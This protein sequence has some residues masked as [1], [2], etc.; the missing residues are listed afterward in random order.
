[1]RYHY[2]GY[3]GE[4]A[5]VLSPRWGDR[6][7]FFENGGHSCSR[8][9]FPDFF[10]FF[11][12]PLSHS[13]LFPKIL[14]FPQKRLSKKFFPKNF[15]TFSGPLISICRLSV[16]SIYRTTRRDNTFKTDFSPA[17]KT[18]PVGTTFRKNFS[19]Y[20]FKIPHKRPFPIKI[21]MRTRIRKMR[22]RGIE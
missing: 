16:I 21:P 18:F 20:F 15:P 8:K 4:G 7:A 19:P 17:G 9:F 14:R 1:M 6:G 2:G 12:V 5:G 10:D 11:R 13:P 22:S 3:M